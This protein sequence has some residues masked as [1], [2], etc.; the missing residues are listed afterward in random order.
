MGHP[1]FEV[2]ATKGGHFMFN[3]TAKNGQV[4]L[5]SQQYTTKAA[6]MNGVESVKTNAPVDDRFKRLEAKNGDYYFDL[7][8]GNQQV[9]GKS[10]MYSS[11]VNMENGISSVKENAPVAEPE[12]TTA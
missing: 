4:I 3:L 8:A 11:K 2:K 1:K 12:E 9:I 10:E 5:T 6:C 7:T